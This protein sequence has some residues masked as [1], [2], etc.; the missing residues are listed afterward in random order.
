MN[1]P[2]RKTGRGR[3]GFNLSWPE[4]RFTAQE[5]YTVLEG[6]LSRVSVHAKINKA[7]EKGELELVGKIKPKTGRPCIVYRKKANE[8]NEQR[9]E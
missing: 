9:P 4:T 3:P 8:T 7:V 6:K 1:E 2:K 5:V